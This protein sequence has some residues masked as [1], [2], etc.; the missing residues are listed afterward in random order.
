MMM[1][2]IGTHDHRPWQRQQK[3]PRDDRPPRP[4]CSPGPWLPV[5]T[6]AEPAEPG[7]DYVPDDFVD[8]TDLLL[9]VYW[10]ETGIDQCQDHDK[11]DV[12]QDFRLWALRRYRDN[13]ENRDDRIQ[14]I[15]KNYRACQQLRYLVETRFFRTNP[16][17]PE[18]VTADEQERDMDRLRTAQAVALQ[19]Y[20]GLAGKLRLAGKLMTPRTVYRY[21]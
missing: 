7:L 9:R 16:P 11:D 6:E 19:D 15:V 2:T 5:R 12:C 13:R 20:D 18:I 4:D 14:K 1:K 8:H 3:P 10:H 21:R 17:L